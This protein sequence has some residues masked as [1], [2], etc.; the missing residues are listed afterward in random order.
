MENP[1]LSLNKWHE[2]RDEAQA[3]EWLD[4]LGICFPN[5]QASAPER[6][7]DIPYDEAA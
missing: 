3:R 6:L 2:N 1:R 7:T 5:E 4:E